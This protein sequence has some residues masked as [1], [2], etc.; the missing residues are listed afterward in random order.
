MKFVFLLLSFCT[1]CKD[2]K[3]KSLLEEEK[4][5]ARKTSGF[6]IEDK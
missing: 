2:C 6:Y 3:N 1:P 4:E 5:E